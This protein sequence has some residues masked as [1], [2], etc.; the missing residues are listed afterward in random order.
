M[1]RRVVK[2][3]ILAAA[4]LLIVSIAYGYYECGCIVTRVYHVESSLVNNTI[5]IMQLSDTHFPHKTPSLN[6]ILSVEEEFKPNI[7]V[8]TGDYLSNPSGYRELLETLEKLVLVEGSGRV[9]G[10]LGNWDFGL[11]KSYV[12]RAFAE[13]GATLLVNN[14]TI[15]RIG[16]TT[17]TLIGLDDALHGHPDLNVSL[18]GCG[19]KILLAHEPELA[20]EA[21]KKGFR[22]L[23][24]TGHCHGGQIRILGHPLVTPKMCI[25]GMLDGLYRVRGGY[26][27]VNAGLGNTYVPV[28]IGVK[29]E[30]VVLYIEPK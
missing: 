18:A 3:L 14:Y 24:F 7:T 11:K 12:Y 13:S 20:L 9:Y 26:L 28:R 5:V 17:I 4:L 19:F 30:I 8:L 1:L 6:K 2:T 10:V 27:V 25:P 23:A 21:F 29:P 15:L 16:P 22:G